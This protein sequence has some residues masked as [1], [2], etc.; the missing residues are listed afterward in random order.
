[1]FAVLF[2]R[3]SGKDSQERQER[4]FRRVLIAYGLEP[5]KETYQD[6]DKLIEDCNN[7]V[8]PKHSIIVVE[9]VDTFTKL[10]LPY[11][12]AHWK[13]I[14][15]NGYGIHIAEREWVGDPELDCR[16]RSRMTEAE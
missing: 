1:M 14:I 4:A 10:P 11:A 3:S 16:K 2:V 12:L 5:W 9:S 6:F 13:P 15:A 8:F 7:K